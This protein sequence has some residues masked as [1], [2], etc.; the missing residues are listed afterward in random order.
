[1]L[2]KYL[3]SPILWYKGDYALPCFKDPC[4]SLYCEINT[5]DVTCI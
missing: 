3:V 2:F 5:A 1:M 4:T